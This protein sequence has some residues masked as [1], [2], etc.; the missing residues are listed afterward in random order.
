M[1][2]LFAKAA[3]GFCPSF[4]INFYSWGSR[5]AYSRIYTSEILGTASSSSA[6]HK[7][8]ISDV[9]PRVEREQEYRPPQ[10][11]APQEEQPQGDPVQGDPVQEDPVQEEQAQIDPR[12]AGRSQRA[13]K[14]KKP[15]RYGH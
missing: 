14:G 13:N 11:P 10:R 7:R 15:Q 2:I 6:I 4:V 1:L 9:T 12:S 3:W 8:G 5:S